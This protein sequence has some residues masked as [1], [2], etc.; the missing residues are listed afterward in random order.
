VLLYKVGSLKEAPSKADK[1]VAVDI[2][3]ATGLAA[4]ILVQRRMLRIYLC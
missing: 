4:T 2:G 3:D 1:L